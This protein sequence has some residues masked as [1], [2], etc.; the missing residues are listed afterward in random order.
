MAFLE[1]NFV[2]LLIVG[3]ILTVLFLAKSEADKVTFSFN[4]K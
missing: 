1:K 3:G 2:P 4:E